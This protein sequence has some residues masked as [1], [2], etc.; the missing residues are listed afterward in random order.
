MEGADETRER[1]ETVENVESHLREKGGDVCERKR[2]INESFREPID[3]LTQLS[4]SYLH[5]YSASSQKVVRSSRYQ[6]ISNFA[7]LWMWQNLLTQMR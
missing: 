3:H 2:T 5:G 6:G 1:P 4:R 7:D